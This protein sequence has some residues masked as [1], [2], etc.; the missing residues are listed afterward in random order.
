[1]DES[2]SGELLKKYLIANHG[3]VRHKLKLRVAI[4]AFADIKNLCI[5]GN[6]VDW[7]VDLYNSGTDSDVNRSLAYK[8]RKR[9]FNGL[10]IPSISKTEKKS[11]PKFI[12]GSYWRWVR[13][14]VLQRDNSTCQNCFSTINLHVHHKTYKNHLEEHLNLQDLITLCKKCHEKEHEK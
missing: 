8:G 11:Y 13:N 2:R 10:D 9:K 3:F 14:M 5:V 1:M 6:K 7:L 12:R 4:Q